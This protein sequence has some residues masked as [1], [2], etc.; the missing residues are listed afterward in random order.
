MWITGAIRDLFARRSTW[1]GTPQSTAEVVRRPGVSF[2]PFDR[3]NPSLAE[4]LYENAPVGWAWIEFRAGGERREWRSHMLED[5]EVPNGWV[6]ILFADDQALPGWHSDDIDFLAR[7][8][9]LGDLIAELANDAFPFLGHD[10]RLRW[11]AG[12]ERRNIALKIFEEDV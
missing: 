12:D 5:V 1:L 3:E 11:L 8:D 4:V 2:N 6:C 9:E 7:G 10:M